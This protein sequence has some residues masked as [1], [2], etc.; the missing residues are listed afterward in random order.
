M[1]TSSLDHYDRPQWV[2]ELL[3]GVK[4]FGCGF[5][6]SHQNEWCCICTPPIRLLGMDRG[7]FT[8]S[9]RKKSHISYVAAYCVIVI[10]HL[11]IKFGKCPDCA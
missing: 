6:R 3:P 2:A 4:V 11:A 1:K 7:N 9:L 10:E 5:D 8:L